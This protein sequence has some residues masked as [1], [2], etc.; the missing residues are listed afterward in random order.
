[1]LLS[2]RLFSPFENR[3]PLVV[4]A[5]LHHDALENELGD[6]VARGLLKCARGFASLEITPLHGEAPPGRFAVPELL[7]QHERVLVVGGEG[8]GKSTLVAH[9]ALYGERHRRHD[10]PPSLLP[11]VLPMALLEPRERLTV[12]TLARVSPAAG[13]ALIERAL[14][15]RRALILVDGIERARGGPSAL[16]E[17]IPAFASAHP[18]NRFVV[19]TRPLPTGPPG[20]RRTTLPGFLTTA[21]LPPLPPS[22]VHP[23]Y[24]FVGLRSPE[25]KA[26][27][28]LERVDALLGAWGPATAPPGSVLGRLRPRDLR[29]VFVGIADH[30]HFR[31]DY[32]IDVGTLL[33]EMTEGMWISD[34][35]AR[36]RVVLPGDRRPRR[37]MRRAPE[38]GPAVV[39][40]LRAHPGL[41]VERRPGW[42]AFDDFGLQEVLVAVRLAQNKGPLL[43][44]EARHDRWWHGA[45]E[46]GAGL[47]EV[48]PA[49]LVGALLHADHGDSADVS[50]LAARCA[51]AAPGL[52]ERTRR[53]VARRFNAL[54]PPESVFA[55]ERLVEIGDIAASA[56]LHVLPRCGPT[57]RALAALVLGRIQHEPAC[58]ALIALASDTALV[59]GR[60]DWPVG[61]DDLNL[62]DKPVATSALAALMSLARVSRMGRKAFARA[63]ARA[64]HDALFEILDHLQRSTFDVWIGEIDA[65]PDPRLMAE[66]T[67]LV[68]SNLARAARRETPRPR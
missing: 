20:R 31:R 9:L 38:L 48:D 61:V 37:G 6:V 8:A 49:V 2:K 51:E 59:E 7:A 14:A 47:P 46:L 23:A 19:T 35:G 24:R 66:L 52:P 29:K 42:L 45:I 39:E 53:A 4:S 43:F 25:R 17:S 13:R 28:Y 16:Q 5:Q 54:V 63:L 68:R 26:A 44:V 11:L 12:D 3:D 36:L 33:R 64:P 32:E 67:D 21:I 18:G 22:R 57:E 27:L 60:L 30:M 34:D 55:A 50:V 10:D 15:E 40:E 56:L 58:G 41:L 62:G 65:A 1:M